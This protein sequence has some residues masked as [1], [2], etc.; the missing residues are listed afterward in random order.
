MESTLQS[1]STESSTG[2]R[3]LPD[4]NLKFFLS[5]N[6]GRAGEEEERL[7]VEL[8][9]RLCSCHDAY[10]RD[11]KRWAGIASRKETG[12][13]KLMLDSG[14]FTAW[15]KGKRVDIKELIATYGEVMGLVDQSK[16]KVYL[17]NLDVIPGRAGVTATTDEVLE[18]IRQSDENFKQ[19]THVFGDCVVPVYHQ[20][21]TES[22]LHEVAA[23]ADYI[24]A[25]PRNDLPEWTRVQ[26]SEEV[27]QKLPKGKR[28]HGLATTGN[29]MLSRVPWWS[30]DSAA[31]LYSGAMGKVD[32]FDNG[33]WISI[34][35][36]KESPD[37]YNAGKHYR[38]AEKPIRDAVEARAAFH[39]I[40][41]DK[42]QDDHM[43]R[44]LLNGLELIE[45]LK[46]FKYQPKDYQP[47]LF[48]L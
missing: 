5:G 20:N 4:Y 29:L 45:W 44:K 22:R 25:S 9:C 33:R 23:M 38:N 19:L 34:K 36:S 46:V 32:V 35:I 12:I 40:S 11:A 6:M 37:R 48:E 39:N 26:W 13:S 2:K 8:E 30:V 18:A 41:V 15:S 31:W 16:V 10:V 1:A 27:H 28:T 7:S 47:T 14:A 43:A 3:K 42:L 21:E 24:C 17:I